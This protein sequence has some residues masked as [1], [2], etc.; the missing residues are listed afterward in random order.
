MLT[1]RN[2]VGLSHAVV[3]LLAGNIFFDV[4][5]G[6]ADVRDLAADGTDHLPKAPGV[7]WG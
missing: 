7:P 5:L 1:L 2:P 6:L 3:A 4:L